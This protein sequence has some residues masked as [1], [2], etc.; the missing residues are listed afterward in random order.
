MIG[1]MQLINVFLFSGIMGLLCSHL[2]KKKGKRPPIWFAMG[3][4]FGIFGLIL[5]YIVPTFT[6]AEQKKPAYQP[7]KPMERSDAWIRMWYYLDP[8]HKQEG[9]FEFPDFINKVREKHVA[10]ETLVWSEGMDEWKKLSELP[11]D[12]SREIPLQPAK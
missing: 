2:A 1:K 12:V 6:K 5:L 8:T 9:P 7:P 4:L 3:F 10:K 11:D